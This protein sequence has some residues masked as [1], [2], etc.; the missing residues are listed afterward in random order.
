MKNKS[1]LKILSTF[2][3]V[4]MVLG[5][6]PLS[7]F[8]G[9]ELPDL[10]SLKAGAYTE[11]NFTYS[12]SNGEAIVTSCNDYVNTDIT[13]PSTLGGY[14]VTSIG[15]YTF[16]NC[17]KITSITIPKSITSTSEDAFYGCENLEN[18]Y[19]TGD[20]ASWCSINFGSEVGG[21]YNPLEF[22]DNF[23]IN[24]ELQRDIVF[25]DTI[26]RIKQ[27][28]FKGYDGL[29]SV[30]IPD[31]VTDIDSYAFFDCKNL[32]K[33]T[34]GS[35]IKHLG[36]LVFYGCI[37]LENTYYTGDL[38]SWC[39]NGIASG[40]LPY[41]ENLYIDENLVCEDFI[42]DSIIE[43]SNSCFAHSKISSLYLNDIK[44][45]GDSAFFSCEKLE[46]VVLENI[47]IISL[48]MFSDCGKLK[49]VY[50]PKSVKIVEQGA[51]YNCENIE[52]VYFEGTEEEWNSIA[53]YPGNIDLFEA[54]VVFLNNTGVRPNFA[55]KGEVSIEDLTINYK[56]TVR[57]SE[58]FK[59]NTGN[60]YKLTYKS[61]DE[62]I[63]TVD[64]NGYVT[65]VGRGSAEITVTLTD[66]YGNEVSDTAIVTVNATWWQWL[67]IIFL[68]GWIWY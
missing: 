20:I 37:N 8:V 57:L 19:Y 46:E 64:E 44:M 53:V 4:V 43:I 52:T 45:I 2:L 67:I 10:F 26:K 3:A 40:I 56:E 62:S 6:A 38:K 15:M 14:P 59:V 48:Y 17:K 28:A 54:K 36:D 7:G 51:F 47:T 25:P 9:I 21:Y 31:N 1:L 16:M 12:V 23:Y 30:V 24:G 29:N 68:F 65:G 34:L 60:D 33:L 27:Y 58:N 5:S 41:T 11:G 66:A 39:E 42:V 50:I 55:S 35:G 22:A 18:V 61:S 63:V 32:T 49:Q 13:I